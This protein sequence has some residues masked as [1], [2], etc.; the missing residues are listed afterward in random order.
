MATFDLVSLTQSLHPPPSAEARHNLETGK[1]EYIYDEDLDDD[2]SSVLSR[3]PAN[4]LPLQEAITASQG[5]MLLLVLK[6]HL[7]EFYGLTAGKIEQYSQTDTS[8]AF[9]RQVTRRPNVRFNPKA[10]VEILE[11]GPPPETLSREQKAE[12]VRTYLEV[13]QSLNLADF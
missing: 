7:K 13:S 11:Q 4:C 1:T 6:E 2:A 12:L 5:C 8:K 3:L 10:T 9:D